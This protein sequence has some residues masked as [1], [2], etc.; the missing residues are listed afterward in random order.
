MPSENAITCS[1][2]NYE[3]NRP[4]NFEKTDL[5]RSE[6]KKYQSMGSLLANI[7]PSYIHSRPSSLPKNFLKVNADSSD[8]RQLLTASKAGQ[9]FNLLYSV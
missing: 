8:T 4:D 1:V 3:D 5:T 6:Q 9:H 7:I 2:G